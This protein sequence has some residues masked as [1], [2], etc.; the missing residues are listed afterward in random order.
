MYGTDITNPDETE[1]EEDE[2]GNPVHDGEGNPVVTKEDGSFQKLLADLETVIEDQTPETMDDYKERV[3]AYIQ[4]LNALNTEAKAS[5]AGDIAGGGEDG[6]QPDGVVDVFDLQLL[7]NLVSQPN[8][9]LKLKEENPKKFNACDLNNDGD[10]S[11][12]DLTVMS[13]ILI[14]ETAYLYDEDDYTGEPIFAARQLGQTNETLRADVVATEGNSQRIA[15]SLSNERD[16]TA[17]QMDVTLPEG[18]RLVGQSLSDRADG[19]QLYANE[20]DGKVRLVGFTS[21]KN[22]FTGNDGAVLYLD[23]E[24]DESYKGGSVKYED[25][26]FA[27]TKSQGVKFKMQGET[28]GVIS[29][30]AEAAKETIYNLG[31]RVMDGLKKGVNILRGDDGAKKVIKK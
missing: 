10:I 23:V 9:K 26:I 18:M 21:T 19:H 30:F 4:A 24:T 3:E 22:A 12:T 11:I 5:R 16:Y 31:G 6:M 28:T 29:R 1:Y 8:E 7:L 17:F 25:I 27:T 15:I 14:G 13:D 20:W 2:F